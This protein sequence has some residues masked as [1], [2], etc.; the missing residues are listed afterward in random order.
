MRKCPVHYRSTADDTDDHRRAC[1][2][3]VVFLTKKYLQQL[4]ERKEY[5]RETEKELLDNTLNDITFPLSGYCG[6]DD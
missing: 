1:N 6:F 3:Y 2:F 4:E 5:L